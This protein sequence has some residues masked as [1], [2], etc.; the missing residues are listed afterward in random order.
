MTNGR[1]GGVFGGP[2]REPESRITR[3]EMDIAASVQQVTEEVVLGMRQAR[4][5]TSPGS[6]TSCLAGGVALNCVANGLLLREGVFERLWIQPAAGD[7]GGALGAA[8]LA[9]HAELG[10]P[11]RPPRG[12]RRASAA[13][14]WGRRTA[15]AQ[16]RAFL[17]AH[18][19]P[20]VRGRR[21]R[22]ARAS[23]PRRWPTARSW[24][25]S[26][27][28]MEFGPRALGARS[29]LGDPR[30]PDTQVAMNLKIKYRESFRPFAPSVLREAAPEYFDLDVESPYMLLVA[31]VREERRR[32][33]AVADLG[34]D[35]DLL[36]IVRAGAQRHLRR[37]PRGLQREGPD[38]GRPGQARLPRPD[39]DVRGL[40]GCGVIVNTSFNVRGEPIVCSPEDAYRCFMRTGIDLLVLEDTLLWKRDQPAQDDDGRWRDEY[41]LD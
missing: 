40:T 41:E 14:T 10:V 35:D 6:A 2:R 16:V 13:A 33:A 19:Y 5:A 23:S 25:G 12:P 27:G 7:A 24:A 21:P 8:L 22:S 11:R 31:P 39:P 20:Y 1:Y 38:G 3:R 9:S 34:D 30:R 18:G 26:V 29:I 28:R 36:R 32:A 37:D 17:D 4:A 15:R